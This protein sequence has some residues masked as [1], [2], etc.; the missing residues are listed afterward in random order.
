M[1][2]RIGQYIVGGEVNNASRNLVFGWLD[3]GDDEGIRFELVGNLDGD[4]AGKHI[5]FTAPAREWNEP[6]DREKLNSLATQ[7]IG[8]ADTMLLRM[9]RVPRGPA[10][11]AYIRGKLVEPPPID[12]KPCL[13]LEWHSQNGRV[14]AEI[15]DPDIVEDPED[16]P[17][18]DAT[19][20]EPLPDP[21]DLENSAGPEIIG[22]RTNEAG[23]AEEMP[24]DDEDEEDD[25]YAL[26]PPDLEDQ[27]EASSRDEDCRSDGGQVERFG[28]RGWDDVIPGIDE[29][30]KRMYEQWDEVFHGEKDEPLV[31]LFDPPMSLPSPVELADEQAAEGPLK[32]LL[33]RL[34]LHNVAIDVCTHFTALD[35]YRWL[36][37]EILPEAQIHP[38]LSSIGFVQHYSTWE[39][40]S[41][42][43][44]EFDAES[45]QGDES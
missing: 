32:T 26:F 25:P 19:A 39:S 30:T 29:E 11:E 7:Q 23:E 34:A 1:A 38:Q 15:V 24:F 21:I 37:E 41:E 22:F 44:A 40:C 8:V 10:D 18:R 33:A 28:C 35:T 12:E 5:R 31:T 4:L 36:I 45:E 6:E 43:E 17:R 20:P 3:F 27:L 42:C 9:V 16:E 2:F 14:V 13:Y